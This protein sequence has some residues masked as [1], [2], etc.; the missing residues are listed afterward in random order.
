MK[1]NNKI[2]L[3]NRIV[4]SSKMLTIANISI[5]HRVVMANVFQVVVIK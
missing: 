3:K 5:F 2:L 4:L 1:Y